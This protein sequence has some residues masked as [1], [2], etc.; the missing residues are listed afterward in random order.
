MKT[1][2]IKLSY[3]PDGDDFYIMQVTN[4]TEFMPGRRLNKGQ[5]SDLCASK[6]WSVTIVP[7]SFK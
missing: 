4:S 6:V 3:Q 2:T 1:K 7:A 5:V